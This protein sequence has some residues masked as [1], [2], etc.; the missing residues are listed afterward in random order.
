MMGILL[1]LSPVL[2]FQNEN[3]LQFEKGV[4]CWMYY[5]NINV[6]FRRLFSNLGYFGNFNTFILSVEWEK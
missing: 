5:T 2:P 3:S 6:L 1:A 4:T